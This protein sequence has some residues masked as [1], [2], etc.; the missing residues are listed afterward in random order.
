MTSPIGPGYGGD[1]VLDE[2]EQAGYPR[3]RITL[4]KDTCLVEVEGVLVGNKIQRPYFVMKEKDAD[5]FLEWFIPS[6]KEV[7]LLGCTIT[8]I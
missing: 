6:K 2:A 7:D 1:A 8:D 5:A 3:D 4:L